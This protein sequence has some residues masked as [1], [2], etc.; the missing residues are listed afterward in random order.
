MISDR[1]NKNGRAYIIHNAGSRPLFEED[2]LT[3]QEISGHF[4][5]DASLVDDN[6][7]V[8]FAY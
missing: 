4:R 5:F 8:E 3:I 6:V 1:R 2:A 7:L